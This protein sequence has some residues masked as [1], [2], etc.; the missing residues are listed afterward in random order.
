[1][2]DG[3]GYLDLTPIS[4]NDGTAF[5]TNIAGDGG[6]SYNPCYSF[7]DNKCQNNVAVCQ[8]GDVVCGQQSTAK[9]TITSTSPLQGTIAYGNGD[10][11]EG[12]PS[13]VLPMLSG[14]SNLLRV[15][16]TTSMEWASTPATKGAQSTR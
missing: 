14:T 6:F 10:K 2:D 1:M 9:F 3:S 15:T 7:Q 11:R 12:T 5:F 13:L 8:A 4:N 16:A